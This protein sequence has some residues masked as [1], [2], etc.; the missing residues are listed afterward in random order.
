MR[1]SAGTWSGKTSEVPLIP[2]CA[3]RLGCGF[4][5]VPLGE[6]TSRFTPLKWDAVSRRGSSG[7]RH[8]ILGPKS[9]IRFP[10]G[11][12]KPPQLVWLRRLYSLRRIVFGSLR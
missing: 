2:F 11:M 12:K 7:K 6:I 5:K 3:S 10:A 1:H 9:G 8:P 4:S